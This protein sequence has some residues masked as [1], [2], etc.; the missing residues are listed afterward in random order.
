LLYLKRKAEGEATLEVV[1]RETDKK[2]LAMRFEQ[3]PF[4]ETLIPD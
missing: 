3:E 4:G 1:G 2:T